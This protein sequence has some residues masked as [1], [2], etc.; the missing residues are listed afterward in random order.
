MAD[1]FSE[2][3]GVFFGVFYGF[4]IF[5]RNLKKIMKKSP[6]FVE[7]TLNPPFSHTAI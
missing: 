2:F 4:F 6:N 3:L 7:K 5:F 1:F